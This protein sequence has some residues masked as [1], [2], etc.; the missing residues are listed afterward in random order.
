MGYAKTLIGKAHRK[1]MPRFAGDIPRCFTYDQWA[2]WHEAA[3]LLSPG[4][5]GPCADCTPDYQSE[6]IRQG[7]CERPGVLFMISESGEIDGYWPTVRRD[8]QYSEEQEAWALARDTAKFGKHSSLKAKKRAVPG[9]LVQHEPSPQE[10]DA[11]QQPAEAQRAEYDKKY[12]A[13]NRD[14]IIANQLK[15][16]RLKVAEDP[17]YRQKEAAAKRA[18]WAEAKLRKE[19]EGE[20]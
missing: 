14:R 16:R 8:G 15:R 7:R 4:E 6:M 11:A 20:T 5:V 3:R 2:Y 9:D 12:Y 19:Q 1:P 13:A 17:T 10:A 18:A